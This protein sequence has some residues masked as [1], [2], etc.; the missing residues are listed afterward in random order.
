MEWG[1]H[2]IPLTVASSASTIQVQL[3]GAASANGAA[4]RFSIVGVDS[5]NNPT[6]SALGAVTGTSNATITMPVSSGLSYYLAVTATPTEYQ[7]LGWE[8]DNNP[9][10][11]TFPYSVTITGATPL[12]GAQNA[13]TSYQS[14]WGS[15]AMDLNWNTNGNVGGATS[16]P[17]YD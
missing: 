4:W 12:Q 14:S 13:C 17:A 11:N 7:E 10:P 6:Y 8:G 9:T 5:S 15:D 1:T 2:I 3:T 16:C